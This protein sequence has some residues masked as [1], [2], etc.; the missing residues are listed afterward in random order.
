MQGVEFEIMEGFKK[1]LIRHNKVQLSIRWVAS[2]TF[3]DCYKEIASNRMDGTFGCS[4]FSIIPER[5]M[6]VGFSPTYI[7]DAS[8]LIS[9]KNVPIVKTI[10]EF[11]NVFSRLKAITIRGTT[12]EKDLIRVRDQLGVPFSIEYIPSNENILRAIEQR[13]NSFGYIDL[14][15]YLMMFKEKPTIAVNRQNILPIKREGYGV[16]Y[17]QG[18]TWADPIRDYFL[19]SDFKSDLDKSM[20]RYLDEEV[21]KTVESLIEYPNDPTFIL[22]KEKEIQSRNLE[23][24]LAQIAEEARAKNLL[25]VLS[26]VSIFML[27]TIVVMYQKR[28]KQ[29]DQIEFQRKNIELKNSQ[30]EK[31]NEHLLAID[32]EKNNLIKILAHDLRTPINQVQGL[33]HLLAMEK[34]TLTSDQ[35]EITQKINE[36]TQRLNKMITNILDI[37]S[38]ENN[39]VNIFTEPVNISSL[40]NQV[41][42]SFEKS[43]QKKNIDLQFKTENSSLMMPGD[44]LFLTQV[45]ENLISNAIKFSPEGQT[46]NVLAEELKTKLRII[47]E[48]YGPGLTPEDQQQAFKKFAKLSAK[49]T[50]GETSTGLGLSIVKKYVEMMGGYVWCESEP[51]KVTRFVTEFNKQQ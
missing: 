44:P 28:N 49:P 47:V 46:V 29:K 3:A 19:S 17:P 16:I 45:Y 24:S 39:R 40:V 27:V 18:S 8:V 31:R 20:P 25:I 32:E 9:S 51:G 11:R 12:Y 34:E 48:D 1:Y 37:E 15:V 14:P 13:S 38:L 21:Y 36:A 50:A 43:A 41:V 42:K 35:T 30:L 7:S 26:T 10:D 33:A 22:S 5:Q 23:D 6:E 2:K 4:A